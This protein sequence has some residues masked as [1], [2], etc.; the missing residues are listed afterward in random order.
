VLSQLSYTP[1]LA[2][3]RLCEP[4][5]GPVNAK[6]GN[7]SVRLDTSTEQVKDGMYGNR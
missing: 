6:S 4:A 7:P 1:L 5:D 3:N 2:R